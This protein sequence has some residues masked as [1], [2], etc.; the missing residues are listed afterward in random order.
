MIRRLKVV[1]NLP[2]PWVDLN[3]RRQNEKDYENVDLT[4]KLVF[5]RG[6]IAICQ[7][8]GIANLFLHADGHIQVDV[9]HDIIMDEEDKKTLKAKARKHFEK[10]VTG[11]YIDEHKKLFARYPHICFV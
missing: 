1:D 10:I 5:R 11:E 4:K 3:D 9:W 2:E 8:V 6:D 7:F